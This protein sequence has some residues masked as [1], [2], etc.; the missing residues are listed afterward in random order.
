MFGRWRKG[1]RSTPAAATTVPPAPDSP[2]V[3]NIE[4]KELFECGFEFCGP[5]IVEA[6]ALADLSITLDD[7][8]SWPDE[9]GLIDDGLT[10]CLWVDDD[11]VIEVIGHDVEFELADGSR[12]GLSALAWDLIAALRQ[13]FHDPHDPER[14]W[15][16][17]G[18]DGGFD[19]VLCRP[20][21]FDALP[22]PPRDDFEVP[23]DLSG[24]RELRRGVLD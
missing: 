13:R 8:R 3:I 17:A 9:S 22:G 11:Y 5:R 19:L 2:I 12:N 15:H 14:N 18:I 20:D 16:V 23:L 7:E 6:F 1:K 21:Q 10:Q 24:A 4:R